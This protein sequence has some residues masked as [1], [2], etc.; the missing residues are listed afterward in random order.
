MIKKTEPSFD[1]QEWIQ[2]LKKDIFQQTSVDSKGSMIQLSRDRFDKLLH[3]LEQTVDKKNHLQNILKQSDKRF[4]SIAARL[5]QILFISDPKTRETIYI[6]PRFE[7]FFGIPVQASKIPDLTPLVHRDD[8]EKLQKSQKR[9]QAGETDIDYRVVKADGSV[10]WLRD[11]IFPVTDFQGGV[12][13]FVGITEDITEKKLIRQNLNTLYKAIDQIPIGI[14]ML[15]CDRRIIF[16]NTKYRKMIDLSADD[17]LGKHLEIIMEHQNRLAYGPLIDKTLRKNIFSGTVYRY[18]Q[19]EEKR[20][21]RCIVIPVFQDDGDLTHYLIIQEDIT[22]IRKRQARVKRE[23][24][25]LEE[26][27]V[28][29]EDK[30][31]D[32]QSSLDFQKS[33]SSEIKQ[34]L[35]ESEKYRF[36]GELVSSFAHEAKNPLNAILANS[37]VLLQRFEEM[38]EHRPFIDHIQTQVERLTVLVN[39]MLDLGKPVEHY[40]FARYSLPSILKESISNFRLGKL[41]QKILYSPPSDELLIWADPARLQQVFINLLRNAAQHSPEKSVITIKVEPLYEQNKVRIEMIDRGSGIDSETLPHIFEPFYTT[42]KEG[43]GLGLGIVKRLVHL[44]EGDVSLQN[45]HNS[46]GCTAKVLLPLLREEKS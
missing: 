16:A 31:V 15:D 21:D 29:Q 41:K 5:D 37:E 24:E 14:L 42:R 13:Q 3:H 17:L 26:E 27:I 11:R 25:S 19:K 9:W 23:Q 46:P 44:H 28:E 33:E 36:F 39:D 45:N 7:D 38:A 20:I 30:L 18:D 2:T 10:I 22:K 32:L 40:N 6:S 4:Q 34:K 35:Q 1:L 8:R 12:Q 43:S